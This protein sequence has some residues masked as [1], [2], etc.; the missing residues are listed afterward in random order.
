MMKNGDG[1]IRPIPVMVILIMVTV[2]KAVM[3]KR[4]QARKVISAFFSSLSSL[5][6]SLH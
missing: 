3:K 1:V 5:P 6:F 4:K 2:M